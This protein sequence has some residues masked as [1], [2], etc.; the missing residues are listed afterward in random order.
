MTKETKI[1]MTAI[2]L[3]LAIGIAALLLHPMEHLFRATFPVYAVFADAQGITPG[4]PVLHAGV[5]VGQLRSISIEEGRAVLHLAID[6][7]A[8]IPKDAAFSITTSGLLGDT[9]VKISGGDLSAGTLAS[10]AT[11]TER[12]DPRM[13]A[14]IDKADHLMDSAE[15]MQQAIESISER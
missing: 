14:L 1:G 12:K 6:R 10:G 13:D 4:A 9:Y 2:L 15:K 11:V 5:R 8:V 7:K 3:F